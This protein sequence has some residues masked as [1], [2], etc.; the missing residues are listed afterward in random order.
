MWVS[1]KRFEGVLSRVANLENNL[2]LSQESGQSLADALDY[3][4]MVSEDKI[5]RYWG[6]SFSPKSPVK[7]D[8]FV[9][10]YDEF[11][12]DIESYLNI[13]KVSEPP[14]YQKKGVKV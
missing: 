1:K 13:E 12:R 4:G 2:K 5:L 7:Y 8:E 10:K 3:A 6:R 14:R 11:K 9:A